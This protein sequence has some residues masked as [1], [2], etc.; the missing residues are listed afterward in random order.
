MSES[1]TFFFAMLIKPIAALFFLAC[2]LWIRRQIILRFPA[3][4]LKNLLLVRLNKPRGS[5]ADSR[6]TP[7][8]SVYKSH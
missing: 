7:T 5:R 1:E 4:K 8:E 3:G 2:L 6:A